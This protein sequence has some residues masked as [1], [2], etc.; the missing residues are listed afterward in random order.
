MTRLPDW[1]YRGADQTGFMTGAEVAG[2]LGNYALSF[3]APVLT[4]AR[5][6]SV[7]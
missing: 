6:R 5:V 7:T 4:Q 1:S 3:D 2:F